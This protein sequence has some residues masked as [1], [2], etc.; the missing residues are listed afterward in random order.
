MNHPPNEHWMSYLYGELSPSARRAADSHLRDCAECRDRVDRWRATMGLL[1]ADHATLTLPRRGQLAA[2]WQPALRWALAASVI[3]VAGFLAGRATGPSSADVE[4]QITAARD[5][6]AT[7]LRTRYQDDLKAI[8]AATVSATTEQNKAFLTEF[9]RQFNE[10]RTSERRDFVAA[11][12]DLSAKHT[13]DLLD[14]RRDLTALARRTGTGFQQAESQLNLLAAY[15]PA[16]GN[17]T[18]LSPQDK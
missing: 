14:L 1:D 6:L 15:L 5:Q 4:R 16:G 3:L 8:A 2:A 13:T 18:P 12:D 10:A 9:N 7:E 17:A 11:L